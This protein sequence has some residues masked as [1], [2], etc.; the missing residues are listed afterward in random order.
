METQTCFWDNCKTKIKV[1]TSIEDRQSF[2]SVVGWCSVHQEAYNIYHNL[3][4]AYAKKHK[5]DW[6]IGSLSYKKHKK[7]LDQLYEL[8]GHRAEKQSKGDKE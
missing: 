4:K 2:F 6:P 5:I 8:A 7:A 1:D 3:E